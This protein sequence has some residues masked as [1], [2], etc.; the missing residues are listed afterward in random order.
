MAYSIGVLSLRRHVRSTTSKGFPRV[1]FKREAFSF[2]QSNDINMFFEGSFEYRFFK[3]FKI[4]QDLK[5][6]EENNPPFKIFK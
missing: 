2:L 5:L 3:K 1:I 4:H 6:W